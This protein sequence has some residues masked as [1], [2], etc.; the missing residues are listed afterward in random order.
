MDRERS[1]FLSHSLRATVDLLG[2]LLPK[3]VKKRR[4]EETLSKVSLPDLLFLRKKNKRTQ[5]YKKILNTK[6]VT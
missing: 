6:R 2:I 4:W 1:R 5:K 3:E